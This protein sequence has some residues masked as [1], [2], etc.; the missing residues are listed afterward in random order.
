MNET[1][2]T[3]EEAASYLKLNKSTVSRMASDGRLPGHKLPGSTHW[4]FYKSELDT[5]IR[6]GREEI[7]SD[8]H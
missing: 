8:E 2:L 7:E 3:V 1:P 5:A 4:R 6:S